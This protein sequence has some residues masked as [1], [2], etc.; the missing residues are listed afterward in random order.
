ME[1]CKPNLQLEVINLHCNDV[2]K[3]IK[4]QEKKLLEFYRCLPG[5]KYAQLKVYAWGFPGGSVIRNLPA[6]VGDTGSI[7]DP[8]R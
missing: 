3:G 6:D 2:L 4:Y 1:A 5:N 7:S 8:G